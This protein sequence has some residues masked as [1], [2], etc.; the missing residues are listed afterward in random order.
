MTS[1]NWLILQPDMDAAAVLWERL[2]TSFQ[3][4]LEAEQPDPQRVRARLDA[5]PAA[6]T[7]A[8][9]VPGIDQRFTALLE[10][11]PQAL[12]EQDQ[13]LGRFGTLVAAICSGPEVE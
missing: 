13:V 1:G 9:E 8:L 12:A 5:V 3:D 7:A 6:C 4:V 10:T 11:L 2:W